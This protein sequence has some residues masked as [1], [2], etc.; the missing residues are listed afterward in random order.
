MVLAGGHNWPSFFYI[1]MMATWCNEQMLEVSED[2]ILFV[3]SSQLAQLC[4]AICSW[5]YVLK[6][7]VRCCVRL[8]YNGIDGGIRRQNRFQL[9]SVGREREWVGAA[10]SSAEEQIQLYLLF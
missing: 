10:S 9:I 4:G 1:D 3:V 2:I 7:N 6:I 8:Q 5:N